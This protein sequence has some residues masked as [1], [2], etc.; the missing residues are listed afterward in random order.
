MNK[1]ILMVIGS[2]SMLVSCQSDRQIPTDSVYNTPETRDISNRILNDSTNAELWA[3]RGQILLDLG[4]DSLAVRDFITAANIDTSNSTYCS[5]VANIYYENK[6]I[7]SALEWYTKALQRNPRD[8]DASLA[9]ARISLILRD[10]DKALTA[11]NRV[12]KENPNEPKAYY[13]KGLIYDDMGNQNKALSSYQTALQIDPRYGD[14]YLKIG[15]IYQERDDST[16]LQ[17]FQN[18]YD[19]DSNIIGLYARGMYYQD[20]LRYPSAK[21]EYHK[22]IE[23]NP[24]FSHP[25]FNMG[26]IYMKQDSLGL[27]EQYFDQCLEADPLFADAHYQKGLIDEK[28]GRPK[29]A[30]KQFDMAYSIDSHSVYIQKKYNQY[31]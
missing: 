4:A 21:S 6:D 24:R 16:C 13:T 17:Y 7:N 5:T 20:H 10:Y 9:Y 12:L 27:A 11:V 28:R 15:F 26:W 30:K 3:E 31:L 2:I 25:Y 1:I 23:F 29:E 8:Q 14:A 19:L 22:C 18:A